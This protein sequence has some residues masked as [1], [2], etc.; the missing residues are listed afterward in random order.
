M[1]VTSIAAVMIAVSGPWLPALVNVH[2]NVARVDAAAPGAFATNDLAAGAAM[3]GRSFG[4]LRNDICEDGMDES[5]SSTGIDGK[6]MLG[7]TPNTACGKHRPRDWI[8][9]DD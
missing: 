2:G 8:A 5:L 6:R 1:R 4:P 7:A 3:S 9:A